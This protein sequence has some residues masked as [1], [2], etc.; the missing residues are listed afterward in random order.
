MK[1]TSV[2]PALGAIA[3]TAAIVLA[4]TGC[5][6]TPNA[7]TASK[8]SSQEEEA[9]SRPETAA[10]AFSI[11]DAWVK[12]A[13]ADGMT[14]AFGVIANA[15]HDDITIVAA[16]TDAAGMAELH[17]VA[18]D[19]SGAMVMGEKEGGFVIAGDGTHV[20]EPGADHIMLMG[21]R[22]A[23]EPGTEVTVT[24]EF[25][26]GSTTDFTAMVKEFTGANESYVGDSG[27]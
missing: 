25:S 2:R 16:T 15:G 11:S 26:D 20:L 8:A 14:G 17:E 1:I 12:A 24:L 21:L 3:A 22:G 9:H 6:A 5:T 4:L 7:D 10:E 27:N 13:A 23:L 18:A 19:A